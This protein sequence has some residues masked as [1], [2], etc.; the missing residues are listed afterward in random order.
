MPNLSAASFTVIRSNLVFL[1]GKRKAFKILAVTLE[2]QRLFH[3]TDD[4]IICTV[5]K[6]INRGYS[7]GYRSDTV[8]KLPVSINLGGASGTGSFVS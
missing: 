6:L 1:S 8:S 3:K 2:P 4:K 7:R 5:L